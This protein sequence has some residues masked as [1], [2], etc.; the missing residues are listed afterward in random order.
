MGVWQGDGRCDGG[1]HR[2]QSVLA[3]DAG[4]REESVAR[5]SGGGAVSADDSG[6]CGGNCRAAGGGARTAADRGRMGGADA[7][8]SGTSGAIREHAARGCGRVGEEARVR[9]RVG[10][11]GGPQ[12]LKTASYVALSG[13]TKGRALSGV[14]S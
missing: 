7:R 2:A 1:V 6:A 13:T 5:G 4:R 9:E 12:W 8:P 11:K 10:I 14:W 3:D